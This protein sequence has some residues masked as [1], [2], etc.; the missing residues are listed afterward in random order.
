[1]GLLYTI[2]LLSFRS[3]VLPGMSK[4]HSVGEH[5]ES[6]GAYSISAPSEVSLSL[7]YTDCVGDV[8]VGLGP[9]S[10]F[11]Y[12]D[13]L[14]SSGVA[15]TGSRK[16]IFW[17]EMCVPLWG[18]MEVLDVMILYLWANI[19]SGP[20][21]FRRQFWYFS[22]CTNGSDSS[23]FLWLHPQLKNLKR[24]NSEPHTCKLTTDTSKD[25]CL[26]FWRK[27][28][29]PRLWVSAPSFCFSF[30]FVNC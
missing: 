25:T 17:C 2:I 21:P 19:F 29:T 1:M 3:W 12:F 4:A 27:P 28:S 22:M 9:H 18:K 14:W 23:N 5:F 24:R 13:Q 30:L 15:S 6:S 11:L 8:T 26:C 16:R 10:H 7:R 20:F